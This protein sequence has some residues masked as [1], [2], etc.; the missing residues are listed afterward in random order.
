MIGILVDVTRC[1]GCERCV[2]ACVKAHDLHAAGADYDR[3]AS[4]DRLSEHLLSSVV[5]LGEGHFARKSCMHCLEASCVSACLVGG[6]SRSKEG[7]VL[8]DPEK[9]IGCRYCMLACPFHIPRYEWTQT[10]PI[11]QKCDFCIPRVRAGLQPACVEACPNQALTFGDR[12]DLLSEAHRRI[13]DSDRYLPRVW[14]EREL[15]GTSILYVSDVDLSALGW[16]SPGTAP[17]PT[18]TEPLI[19]KTPYIGAAVLTGI[20]ALSW[21]IERRS[22]LMGSNP[23]DT[24]TLKDESR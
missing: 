1:T 7:A 11:V 19:S 16:P 8:Y 3:V 21:I 23:D 14:G 15:G 9:C 5:P 2:D 17:I 12:E 4:R 10:F 22:R 24:D 13:A 18:L 20:Y 6:L